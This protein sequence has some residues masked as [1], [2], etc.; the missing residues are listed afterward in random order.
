[1]IANGWMTWARQILPKSLI[2]RLNLTR[3]GTRPGDE[4]LDAWILCGEF[5]NKPVY[6]V[7]ELEDWRGI[8][9]GD[10]NF[11]ATSS[12]RSFASQVMATN[13]FLWPEQWNERE[14]NIFTLDLGHGPGLSLPLSN[15]VVCQHL[16][17]LRGV[18]RAE[19]NTRTNPEERMILHTMHNRLLGMVTDQNRRFESFF[20]I[21]TE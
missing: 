9:T 6:G 13:N 3:W 18:I 10:M 11:R 14:E 21:P 20:G 19:H 2:V 1:M 16:C 5:V 4:F 12:R 8:G 7:L 15:V 17:F